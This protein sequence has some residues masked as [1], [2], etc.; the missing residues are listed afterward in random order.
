MKI[1]ELGWAFELPTKYDHFSWNRQAYWSWYPETHVGRPAG[2]ATPDSADQDVTKLTR[3]DAFDFN[4]T[5]YYCNFAKL[6]DSAGNGVGVNFSSDD[7][8][9]C[10]G[11]F[12]T[13]AG[14]SWV[15]E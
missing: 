5:K 10:R 14:I 4:S 12:V 7:R 3:P 6:T 9:N 1:Q 11:D 8:E 2:T 15:G 13:T